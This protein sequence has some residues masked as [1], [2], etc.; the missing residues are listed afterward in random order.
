MSEKSAALGPLSAVTVPAKGEVVLLHSWLLIS[1]SNSVI[2][3]RQIRTAISCPNFLNSW[4]ME[5]HVHRRRRPALSCVEC[6]RRKIR[7][8]RDNPCA[9]CTTARTQCSYKIYSHEFSRQRQSLDHS[10]PGEELNLL[11]PVS[12]SFAASQPAPQVPEE[13][14]T[15]SLSIQAPKVVPDLNDLL[16]RVRKLEQSLVSSLACDAGESARGGLALQSDVQDAQISQNKMR[17]LRWSHW[18]GGAS[19]VTHM[20]ICLIGKLADSLH[21]VQQ[22]HRLLQCDLRQWQGRYCPRK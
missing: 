19:E 3:C 6:R 2:D 14:N 9:N 11:T 13:N 4:Y 22:H 5:R 17:V 7:C 18:E 10:P 21:K 16:G 12:T 1:F 8:N 20:L 15:M